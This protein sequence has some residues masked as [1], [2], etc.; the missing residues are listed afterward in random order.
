MKAGLVFGLLIA[1][2]FLVSVAPAFGQTIVAH[3]GASADAP[4]N[5]LRAFQLAFEQGAD[6]IEADCHLTLDKQIIFT[7]DVH[8]ERVSGVQLNVAE[9]CF[10]ELRELDVGTWKHPRFS[11]SRMPKLSEIC[12]IIP[13]ERSF[14]I[15]IKCGPEIVPE[16]KPIL[17]KSQLTPGQV[18]IISFNRDVV[19]AA[20]QAFPE[21]DCYWLFEFRKDKTHGHWYPSVESVIATA[22]A[23]NAD[24]VDVRAHLVPVNEQFATACRQAGLSLHAWTVDDPKVAIRLAEL[25]FDSITTNRPG[26]LRKKMRLHS[27]S[28][29]SQWEEAPNK[30]P[31]RA[32][33]GV[34]SN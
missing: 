12:E 31:V 6:A 11:D 23:I 25:G 16:L 5:T 7:H 28:A 2:Q 8:T 33:E 34:G 22:K 14:Y 4:E 27:Q 20:K 29:A 32:L 19:K 21:I 15:E 17:S 24:G 9:T 1:W 10:D 18:R 30:T 13:P 26:E 3:R